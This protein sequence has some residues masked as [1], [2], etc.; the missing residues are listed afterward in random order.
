MG[1]S[2]E[3][4]VPHVAFPV[5]LPPLAVRTATGARVTG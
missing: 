3:R 4:R 5:I 2:A 1:F